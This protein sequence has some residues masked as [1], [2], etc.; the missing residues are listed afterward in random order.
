MLLLNYMTPLGADDFAY[1]G[2]TSFVNAVILEYRHYMG[3]GGRSVAHLLT[4]IFLM[5]PKNLFNILNATAFVCFTLLILKFAN[6]LKDKR[7]SLPVYLFIVFALWLYT[8]RFGEVILWVTGSANYL[9][10]TLIILSF[11]LPYQLHITERTTLNDKRI[12]IF[13]MFLF[14]VVAGWCSENTSGGMIL[15]VISMM[16][17]FKIH[18]CKLM[19]WMFGGLVGNIVGFIFMIRAPGNFVR[20]DSVL[21]RTN[22]T[23]MFNLINRINSYTNV[24]QDKF[25]VLIAVFIVLMAI[26]YVIGGQRW[27]IFASWLYFCASIA[28]FYATTLSPTGFAGRSVFGATVF[29]IIACVISLAGI[30]AEVTSQTIKI[31]C[32]SFIAVLFFQY[33]TS[34][35]NAFHCIWLT[36]KEHTERMAYIESQ[37]EKKNLNITVPFLRRTTSEHNAMLFDFSGDKTHWVNLNFVRVYGLESITAISR[38]EHNNRHQHRE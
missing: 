5:M 21:A 3:W 28:A 8:L 26:Q 10:T 4:R 27:R 16:V 15:L 20:A 12:N 36:H 17:Y 13:L 31:A 30:L 35:I 6:A 1:S 38:A 14:G 32:I 7:H 34:S 25:F 2:A 19:K 23:Y 29:L 18:G 11:L 9:W 33:T 22:D 37:I 24:L